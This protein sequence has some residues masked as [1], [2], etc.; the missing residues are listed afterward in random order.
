MVERNNTPAIAYRPDID[1]LRAFAVL[2]VVLYHA[3]PNIL[4]GGFIGVDV[5]FVISG[6]LIGWIIMRDLEQERFSFLNFYARRIRRIFPA[7]LV[8]L[9]TALTIGWFALLPDEYKTLGKHVLGGA[10]FIDNFFLWQ[11][12]GYFDISSKLKPLLHLWSLGIEEQFYII[13]PLI[14]YLSCIKKINFYLII[15]IFL[16][17]S[18]ITNIYAYEISPTMD[19]YSPLT[20]FW[21][22]LSGSLLAAC[23][24][25]RPA[26]RIYLLIDK[27]ISK[28]LWR[29]SQKN[30][31]QSLSLFLAAL[32]T[33]FL[34]ISLTFA[35]S[36]NPWPAWEAILPVLGA[37]FFIAAGPINAISKYIFCNRISLFFGKIS[38]PLYLWHWVLLSYLFII[39]GGDTNLFYQKTFLIFLAIF[40]AI[41]THIFVE[42]PIRF[43]KQFIMIKNYLLCICMLL[44]SSL[45]YLVFI[46]EGIYVRFGIKE[47]FSYKSN[48]FNKPNGEM[49]KYQQ[50]CLSLYPDWTMVEGHICKIQS[51]IEDLDTIL[52]GDSYV[53]HL[54]PGLVSKNSPHNFGVFPSSGQPP[55]YDVLV[56][57][58]E[59]HNG[60]ILINRAYDV[61]VDNSNIKNVILS[62]DPNFSYS[63]NIELIDLQDK[64]QKN[65]DIIFEN[66]MRRSFKKL[67]QAHKKIIFVLAPPSLPFEVSKCIQRPVDFLNVDRT[68]QFNKNS[69]L[70][71]KIKN[72]FNNL[73]FKVLKDFPEVIIY[74][75]SSKLC[76]DNYCYVKKNGSILYYDRGHLSAAGSELVSPDLLKLI[77]D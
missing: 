17:L 60:Y 53:H 51:T 48:Y 25:K 58:N 26:K 27:H 68:C 34:I 9:A 62:I 21:E 30:N 72:R 6:Y 74:H 69:Y 52:I 29:N 5:F 71:D 38:Y 22:L 1:G 11:E 24:R 67:V 73:L 10:A 64:L 23:V 55:F 47:D 77:E 75:L 56:N 57:N 43:N 59:R 61:A 63:D 40:L 2:S 13:F 18:F 54:F 41:L 65:K 50:K 15:L 19:F 37:S 28:L 33:T 14:L 35:R 66:S 39:Y 31:G 45:G 76:D 8:V 3:F 46:N 7:L 4:R 36:T 12:S 20:R 70:N 49:L 44:L 42:R 32:G 16:V